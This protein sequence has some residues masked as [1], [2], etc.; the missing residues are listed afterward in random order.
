MIFG[1]CWYLVVEED[2][3]LGE[4]AELKQA[5]MLQSLYLKLEGQILFSRSVS[6]LHSLRGLRP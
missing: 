1:R 4:S 3:N 6:G 5:E 2:K